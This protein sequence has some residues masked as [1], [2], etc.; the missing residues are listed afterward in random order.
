MMSVNF[1]YLGDMSEATFKLG[2][3][4]CTGILSKSEPGKKV[5]QIRVV[6]R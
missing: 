6:D 3:L 5:F 1:T 2:P 4:K